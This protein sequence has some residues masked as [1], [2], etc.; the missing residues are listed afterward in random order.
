MEKPSSV[1]IMILP[2]LFVG[3][4]YTHKKK[5]SR[6]TVGTLQPTHSMISH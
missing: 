3:R 6:G 1:T 5:L 4:N 2:L